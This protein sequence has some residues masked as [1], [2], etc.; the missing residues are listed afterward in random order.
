MAA[1]PEIERIHFEGPKSKNPLAFRHY[2][3]DEMVDGK[4]MT[5]PPA[6]QRRLLA[7]VPRHRRRSVRPRHA[8]CGRGKTAPT[9]SRTPRTA[10]AWRSSSW[11]SSAP[12]SM[13]ST[14]ATSPPKARTLAET[15]KNLDAVVKV[16][17]EE[18]QRTGIKLLWGTANLFSNRRYMH[19]AATS[20]N[21]DAF[22]F[23]AAQVK[24]ALEVTKELGGER[25]HVLG[26]PRRLPESVEHQHEARARSPRPLPAHGRRL[27]QGDRLHRP[28]LHRAQAQGA[29]QAPV[30]FRRGR[31]PQLPARVRSA[32]ITSS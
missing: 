24:K 22:A 11:R 6:V 8:P 12:R 17:K 23:A 7:H 28:V 27:R 20:P 19:G 5:R 16:L 10:P 21:A 32:S 9:R 2:N 3:A 4:T 15:N 25:L 14:I 13:R 30:R 31:L 26:R 29:D 18:Q 1:F